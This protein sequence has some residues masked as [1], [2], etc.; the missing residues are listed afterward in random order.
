[1]RSKFEKYPEGVL[2]IAFL[3]II[4][5]MIVHDY[6]IITASINIYTPFPKKIPTWE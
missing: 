6:N 1:M 3:L 5:E 2:A 4:P